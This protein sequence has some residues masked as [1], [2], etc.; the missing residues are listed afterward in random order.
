MEVEVGKVTHYYS[1]AKAAIVKLTDTL[2]I[3]DKIHI[4][5]ATTNFEQEVKSMELERE[6][7]QAATA[8]QEIGI[9]VIKKVRAKDTVYKTE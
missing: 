7:I 8:G 1:N 3:G 4:T 2:G 9:A 5:G 6:K